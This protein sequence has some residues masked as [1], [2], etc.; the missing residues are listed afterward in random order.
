MEVCWCC[1][2][3]T[4]IDRDTVNILPK[5]GSR[6]H[7]HWQQMWNHCHNNLLRQ[8]LQEWLVWQMRRC[9]IGLNQTNHVVLNCALLC[10]PSGRLRV[11]APCQS[12]PTQSQTQPSS[13]ETARKL[14]YVRRWKIDSNGQLAH[15]YWDQVL[16]SIHIIHFI[17]KY[18]TTR[19]AGKENSSKN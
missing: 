6:Q 1:S 2:D 18:K 9:Q 17:H 12:N 5:V 11:Q 15:S 4:H 8:E 7:Y 13:L 14:C 3:M 16:K 10:F 19:K